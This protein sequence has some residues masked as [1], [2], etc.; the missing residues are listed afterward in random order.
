MDLIIESFKRLYN[1]G[2]IN[3]ATLLTM[4]KHGTITEKDKNY[5]TGKEGE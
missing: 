1:S 2:Q 4:L 3:D 5:I